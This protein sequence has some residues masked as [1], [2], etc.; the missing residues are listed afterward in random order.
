MQTDD[1]DTVCARRRYIWKQLFYGLCEA[2]CL[3]S[4]INKTEVAW[5]M[6]Y[7]NIDNSNWDKMKET[8]CF[9]VC[10][11][12]FHCLLSIMLSD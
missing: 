12:L 1:R 2:S 3:K 4:R 8:K 6:R 10:S 5:P 9:Q 11:V 7:I